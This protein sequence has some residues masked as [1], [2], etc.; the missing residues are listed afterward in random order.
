[1]II[2]QLQTVIETLACFIGAINFVQPFVAFNSHH[3]QQK[4]YHTQ[5]HYQHLRQPPI[6]VE[7]LHQTHQQEQ[8][9]SLENEQS[10][11]HCLP[12]ISSESLLDLDR[13]NH[14]QSLSAEAHHENIHLMHVAIHIQY[15]AH[16]HKHVECVGYHEKIDSAVSVAESG[17]PD[18]EESP[19][20]PDHEHH[21]I[22]FLVLSKFTSDLNR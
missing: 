6:V 4:A 10:A 13:V 17:R 21:R 19:H 8:P 5:T 14:E 22:L 3:S 15:C 16:N 20:A 11:D 18:S 1:L 9:Q 2:L 7:Q 12:Q